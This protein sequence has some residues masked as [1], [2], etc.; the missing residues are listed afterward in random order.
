MKEI[1]GLGDYVQK[2]TDITKKYLNPIWKKRKLTNKGQKQ[3]ISEN[4]QINESSKTENQGNH[5]YQKKN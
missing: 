1:L 3:N 5:N 4:K 2:T